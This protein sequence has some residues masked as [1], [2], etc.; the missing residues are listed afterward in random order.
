MINHR[1][2]KDASSV[3]R[4][5]AIAIAQKIAK[6]VYQLVELT[7]TLLALLESTVAAAGTNVRKAAQDRPTALSVTTWNVLFAKILT[8]VNRVLKTLR[9][10]MRIASALNITVMYMRHRLA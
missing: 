10:C 7:S 1:T 3:V 6:F 5:D 4:P 9:L 8:S 2:A